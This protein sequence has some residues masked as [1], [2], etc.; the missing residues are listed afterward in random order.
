MA[1]GSSI[2]SISSIIGGLSVGAGQELRPMKTGE[3]SGWGMKYKWIEIAHTE[4]T[5]RDINQQ[6]QNWCQEKFGKSGA[7]WFEKKD[8]F[9]F[10]SEK[11]LTM[12]ILRWS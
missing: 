6:V 5:P 3:A 9:Y 11:D 4:D 8:K 7:R 2:P 12:F 1:T 10:K